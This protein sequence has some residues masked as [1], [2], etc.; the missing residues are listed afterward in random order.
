M[1]VSFGVFMFSSKNVEAVKFGNNGDIK[2][3]R[4]PSENTTFSAYIKAG[5]KFHVDMASNGLYINQE[6]YDANPAPM[7]YVDSNSNGQWDAGETVNSCNITNTIKPDA[8]DRYIDII[9]KDSSNNVVYES[10]GTNGY[11]FWDPATATLNYTSPAMSATD[12]YSF[13]IKY[14]AGSRFT[15]IVTGFTGVGNATAPCTDVLGT[16]A[17]MERGIDYNIAVQNSSGTEIPGRIWTKTL[18]LSQNSTAVQLINSADFWTISDS[19]YEY[20]LTILDYYGGNS[21][22]RFSSLGIVDSGGNPINKSTWYVGG[23]PL[24]STNGLYKIFFEAPATDLPKSIFPD[25][26]DSTGVDIAKVIGFQ[27]TGPTYAREGNILHWITPEFVGAYEIL[28][29]TNNNGVYTDSVDVTLDAT[30]QGGTLNGSATN[31]IG[32]HW[33]GLDGLGNSVPLTREISAKINIE[34]ISTIY[35]TF[36]DV[37]TFGGIQVQQVNGTD[38]GNDI[39]YWDDTGYSGDIIDNSWTIYEGSLD[40]SATID[41]SNTIPLI[42]YPMDMT[43]G[44]HS[45]VPGG[46]HGW[47][48]VIPDN[49]DLTWGNV[50]TIESWMNS[51]LASTV[52]DATKGTINGDTETDHDHDGIPDSVEIGDDPLNPLDTD[53]DGIPDWLDLDSDGD[54][55]PDSIEKGSDGTN[56]VDTDGD[57]TPDYLDLDSDGDGIPDT[58]E[59]DA[60]PDVDMITDTDKNGIPDVL[61]DYVPTDTDGDGTPDYLDLDSDDDGIPD[62]VEKGDDGEHPVDTDGDGTPDYLDLDS[63]GDGIPDSVEKGK[64]GNHPVDTDGDGTPDYLDLDSDGD[65]I[66]DSVEKGEDGNHPV[67]TDGDG[68]PDYC[69]LDSDNDGIPDSVEK[70]DDGNHPVDTDGDGVPDYRDLDSDNDTIPDSVEKGKDGNHPVDTDGDGTPDYRDLD[71]DNDGKLDITEAGSDPLHPQDSDGDGIPDYRDLTDLPTTGYN[72][73]NILL[74]SLLSGI[75]TVVFMKVRKETE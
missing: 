6:R 27:L 51:R 74:L 25:P 57:G 32:V 8:G 37:E 72:I 70:G 63:D 71:S 40:N 67:D 75:F 41:Y 69:D 36:V 19:G 39:I 46:V 58:V 3:L 1:S 20:K 12:T 54:G 33:N 21:I 7:D 50:K 28:I 31:P 11:N 9:I 5:E 45:N 66:P 49:Y 30:A 23:N 42:N 47:Q 17:G 13:T 65:G 59:G 18:E 22:I 52:L 4:F 55:I 61:E 35:F 26:I 64:D 56:P 38:A 29:D 53:G 2:Y 68:V 24:A 60:D 62:S 48:S 10:S 43:A 34:N 16:T 73:S 44:I 14:R 15:N